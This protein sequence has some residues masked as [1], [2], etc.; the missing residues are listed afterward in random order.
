MKKYTVLCA[1]LCTAMLFTGCK[2]KESAYK[3]LYLKAQQQDEMEQ[4]TANKA[5]EQVENAVVVPMDDKVA[6]DVQVVDNNDNVAVRQ[7]SVS[8]V[9]GNGLK[10]FSVVVGSFGLKANAE[11]LQ[12]IL[13]NQGYDAQ[14]VVNNNVNPI[15]Y[16]VVATTFDS[17][18]DAESSRNSLTSQYPGAWLLYAK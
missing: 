12:Q 14:V 16:R 1:A 10:S 4:R 13:K 2:S 11:G 6:S 9:N 8:V 18:A 7:E 5:Q 17:K 3:Q 15:M